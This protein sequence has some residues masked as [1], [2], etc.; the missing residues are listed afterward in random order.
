MRQNKIIF[1]IIF[2]ICIS[3][4]HPER[5]VMGNYITIKYEGFEIETPIRITCSNFEYYFKNSIDSIVITDNQIFECILEKINTLKP[6]D[7]TFPD[8]ADTRTKLYI[9]TNGKVVKIVCMGNFVVEYNNVT[10]QNDESLKKLI[11]GF[12]IKTKK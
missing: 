7:S 9:H 10:Y 6:I 5:Q 11:S 4:C 12:F 3:A 8:H 2:L 1:F